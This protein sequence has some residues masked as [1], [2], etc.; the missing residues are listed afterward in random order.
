MNNDH[1]VIPALIFVPDM[2]GFT[3]FIVRSDVEIAKAVIPTLLTGIIESN[4]IGLTVSDIQGDAVMFYKTGDL[5]GLKEVIDQCKATYFDFGNKLKMMEKLYSEKVKGYIT[6]KHLGLKFIVHYGEVALTEV[7]GNPRL[8]GEDV[9]ITHR[10]LKN[11]IPFNEYI[12]FTVQSLSF[13]QEVILEN[14]IDW[15]PIID[16]TEN[17]EHIGQVDYKYV[18]L[19]PLNKLI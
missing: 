2:S 15:A 17:Y 13:N 18:E 7:E 5:P 9:I 3:E 14:I 16:G 1:G 8:I 4:T 10:L 12:L 19:S 6:P 11:N